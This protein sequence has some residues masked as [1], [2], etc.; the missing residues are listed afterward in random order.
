MT[1]RIHASKAVTIVVI[2]ATLLFSPF[3]LYSQSSDKAEPR[4][5]FT[6]AVNFCPGGVIFGVYAVNYEYLVNGH[7][8]LIA[9][10][11]YEDIP[12]SY[13]DADIES[14]GMSY[15]LSYRYHFRGEMASEH[16]SAFARYKEYT[17]EG[18]L[19]GTGFDFNT[20]QLTF[21]LAGGKR[22]AWNSGFN[23]NVMFGYGFDSSDR[24]ITPHTQAIEDRMDEYEDTYEFDGGFLG[25][26]SI[27]YAF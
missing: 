16:L 3:G 24:E 19:E 13:T 1:I 7:H 9:R 27:G 26:I 14:Y 2:L 17:G 18:T 15:M 10:F 6:Q 4:S 25:E 11:D 5:E 23:L 22:W 20:P 21:G 12:K 8:G